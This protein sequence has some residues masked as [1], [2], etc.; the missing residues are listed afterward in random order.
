MDESTEKK[1]DTTLSTLHILIDNCVNVIKNDQKKIALTLIK[2]N[3]IDNIKIRMRLSYCWN[4]LV[5]SNKAIFYEA[6]DELFSFFVLNFKYKDHE[7]DFSS[8]EFFHHLIDLEENASPPE[9]LQKLM[10][11]RIHE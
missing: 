6:S 5:R 4:S 8:S 10:E 11:A 7:L 3:Q 2:M 9:A 1:I